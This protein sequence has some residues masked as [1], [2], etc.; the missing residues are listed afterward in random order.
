MNRRP[1]E[2]EGS[3][4]KTE[5]AFLSWVRGVL[6]R[7]WSKH[8]I[9]LEFIKKYRKQVPNPNPKGKKPTIWGMTCDCC[10]K[11][12]PLQVPRQLKGVVPTIEIDHIEDAS[13]LKSSEDLG[14]FAYRLFYVTFD[15]LRPLCKPCHDIYTYMAKHNVSYEEAKGTKE[16]IKKMNSLSVKEQKDE[17][18]AA[19]FLEKE[20]SNA[21]K[22]RECYKKILIK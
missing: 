19:G 18:K 20:V 7:G 6:R 13:S 15:L 21:D 16:V 2:E 4:W 10:K 22:R 17:L 9:K 8:P 14:G 12:F 11:D 3:P 5:S 1:W